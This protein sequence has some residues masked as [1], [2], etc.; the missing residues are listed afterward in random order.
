MSNLFSF[1]ENSITY[2]HAVQEAKRYLLEHGFTELFEDQNFNLKANSKYFVIRDQSSVIAFVTPS[3]KTINQAI[4]LLSH[5]DSPTFRIKPQGEFQHE[6]MLFWN[7]EVYGSPIYASWLNR[8][9]RVAGRVYYEKDQKIKSKL[10][11]F[12]DPVMITGLPIHIDR[13]VNSEGLKICAQ[14]QLSALV[15]LTEK[16]FAKKSYLETLIEEKVGSKHILNHELFLHPI[17]AP[18]FLGLDKDLFSSPRIDN[19]FSA[20][21]ALAAIAKEGKESDR[22]NMIYLAGHE[23]IGSKTYTGA[24]SRF[25]K[26]IFERI[27]G[28]YNLSVEEKQKCI[29]KSAAFSIDGAHALDPKSKERFEP[30]HTPLLGQGVVLKIDS[31][32]AYAYSA[33]L[34]AQIRFIAEKN[35]IQIQHYIKKG[36]ARL[37]STLGPLF[38]E[39]MGIETVDIG[40]PQ[41]SMH[42]I[43]EVASLRDYDQ[44][45]K[46]MG[47]VL[48]TPY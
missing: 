35:K 2:F 4:I 16:S 32:T 14:D 31:S 9:L 34:L 30:R 23:E 1:L 6:N 26:N 8:D 39:K 36:D 45:V 43:K 17:D 46:L 47:L 24:D 18:R 3:K 12:D 40:F 27:L 13:S 41:L 11:E 29:A 10:V 42:A 33:R 37:G 38:L 7:L 28:H 48:K 44:L 25:F 15:T 21:A 5:T 19:L 22:L 20:H